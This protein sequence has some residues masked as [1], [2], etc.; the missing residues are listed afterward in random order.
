MTWR[1]PSDTDFAGVYVLRSEKNFARSPQ[2]RVGQVVAYEGPSQGRYTAVEISAWGRVVEAFPLLTGG[3]RYYYT[4]WAADSAGNWSG[5]LT[6]LVTTTKAVATRP[7]VLLYRSSRGLYGNFRGAFTKAHPFA[8]DAIFELDRYRSGKWRR[9]ITYTV[10]G[11]R[12]T[13]TFRMPG[14]SGLGLGPGR[15]RARIAHNACAPLGHE[16][17][18][19]HTRSFGP[20]RY[21]TF[22]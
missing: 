6:R 8:T 20:Y 15:W 13:R 3:R 22:R 11:R 1:D 9:V 16:G 2:D 4:L 12:G 21:M 14:R 17:V 5:P 7:S 19:Y 18:D 10:A